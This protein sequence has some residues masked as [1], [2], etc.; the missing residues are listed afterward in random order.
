MQG[1]LRQSPLLST[2]PKPGCPRSYPVTRVKR[3]L[4]ALA[5]TLI[6]KASGRNLEITLPASVIFLSTFGAGSQTQKPPSLLL[7][8]PHCTSILPAEPRHFY[9]CQLRLEQ[10]GH[11]SWPDVVPGPVQAILYGAA[12][13]PLQNISQML[14]LSSESLS[15]FHSI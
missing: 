7:F 14:P 8:S 2:L 13:Q 1:P 5:L 15:G 4:I 6:R 11:G 3:P 10:K 12:R 9:G